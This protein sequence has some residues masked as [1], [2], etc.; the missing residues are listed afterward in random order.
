MRIGGS[1]N[2]TLW[3]VNGG[4]NICFGCGILIFFWLRPYSKFPNPMAISV[5]YSLK[6]KIAW[7]NKYL[8]TSKIKSGRKNNTTIM[9]AWQHFHF[10]SMVFVHLRNVWQYQISVQVEVANMISPSSASVTFCIH[11]GTTGETT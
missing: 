2:I 3:D 9:F 1:H 5:Q 11:I 6:Y 4:G 8:K 7:P 10:R